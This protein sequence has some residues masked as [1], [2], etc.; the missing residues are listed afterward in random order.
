MVLHLLIGAF[1]L[2][3]GTTVAR[4]TEPIPSGSKPS[5]EL[6]DRY[7][8]PTSPHHLAWNRTGD[9]LV[10]GSW[11]ES[12]WWG[13]KEYDK[14]VAVFDLRGERLKKTHEFTLNS[15]PTS[16]DAVAF[17]PDD[18]YIAVGNTTVELFDLQENRSVWMTEHGV[19]KANQHILPYVHFSLVFSEDGRQIFT[20]GDG[21]YAEGRNWGVDLFWGRF[22]VKTGTYSVAYKT[23]IL[24]LP[25]NVA[26]TRGQWSVTPEMTVQAILPRRYWV[27]VREMESGKEVSRLEPINPPGA[28]GNPTALALS[29]DGRF[30][31]IGEH[32][33][34]DKADGTGVSREFSKNP[35]LI[36][37][38]TFPYLQIWDVA[39]NRLLHEHFKNDSKDNDP[40]PLPTS[41]AIRSLDISPDGKWLL[42]QQSNGGNNPALHILDMS[43]GQR[44]W[45]WDKNNPAH[46]CRFSPI[47]NIFAC[48]GYEEIL[49]FKQND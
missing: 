27:S 46:L 48:T 38:F 34:L 40:G 39:E 36:G 41:G 44:V 4:A 15:A 42:M 43:S 26:T 8:L 24:T 10:V 45:S 28:R 22:D 33:Q 5:F 17:S 14:H 3:I 49:I 1:T 2:M 11:L 12:H 29:P 23:T 47:K 9:K 6:M 16:P 19:V 21:K 7:R 18:R 31:A 20:V 32:R 35:N 13:K 37:T 25:Q 30:L